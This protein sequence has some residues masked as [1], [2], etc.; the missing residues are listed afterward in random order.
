MA[1]CELKRALR[2]WRRFNKPDSFPLLHYRQFHTDHRRP[3]ISLTLLLVNGLHF[4]I[5]AGSV[6]SSSTSQRGEKSWQEIAAEI[7]A[8]KDLNRSIELAWQLREALTRKPPS[9]S[10]TPCA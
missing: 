3:L 5:P 1:H 7:G 8:E 2:F 6:M 4:A 9:G 10:G